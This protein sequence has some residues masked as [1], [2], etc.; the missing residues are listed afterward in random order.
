MA[1]KNKPTVFNEY[2]QAMG[3]CS[4]NGITGYKIIKAPAAKFKQSW[5]G[6]YVQLKNNKLV[7]V[8]T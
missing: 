4:R 2:W 5:E 3:Y 6:W 8:P 7:S 1:K